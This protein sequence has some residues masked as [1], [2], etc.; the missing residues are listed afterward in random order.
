[1]RGLIITS[2]MKTIACGMRKATS[3]PARQF[4]AR[5]LT[6]CECSG[7]EDASKRRRGMARSDRSM[8]EPKTEVVP[9]SQRVSSARPAK[10]GSIDRGL[11]QL[12]SRAAAVVYAGRRH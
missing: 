5:R 12:M 10:S 7:L 1:M 6:L 9:G 8:G 4:A 11:A 3:T 2:V